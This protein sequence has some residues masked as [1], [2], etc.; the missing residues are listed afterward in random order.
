VYSPPQ[1]FGRTGFVV[2]GHGPA[3]PYFL[4][5]RDLGQ[6]WARQL[7]PPGAGVYPRITFFSPLDGVL[8]PAGPSGAI[9]GI[10]DVTADG[11]T[12]WTAVAAGQVLH[13]ERDRVRLRQPADRVRLGA[14]R[15]RARRAARHGPDHRFRAHLDGLHA[16]P[17]R[18]LISPA[19]P[20]VLA[21]SAACMAHARS[22]HLHALSPAHVRGRA[23]LTV[24][25]LMSGAQCTARSCPRRVSGTRRSARRSR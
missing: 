16:S 14:G 18:R 2:I 20:P 8:V 21:P 24:V 12:T 17:G 5:S 23:R 7:L 22:R 15:G 13:C 19:Q 11:G 9:G 1:F 6:T 3:A 10:F 4:A 25:T